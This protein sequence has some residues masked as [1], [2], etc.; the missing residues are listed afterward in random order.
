M[1]TKV[2]GVCVTHLLESPHKTGLSRFS[3]IH[4]N[5]TVEADGWMD[6]WMDEWMDG[7]MDDLHPTVQ[8]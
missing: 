6:G 3:F 7:W 2:S 1:S 5:H 8:A 4:I